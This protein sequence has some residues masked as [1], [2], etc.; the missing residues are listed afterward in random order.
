MHPTVKDVWHD[1]V[2]VVETTEDKGFR[3][4][5]AFDAREYTLCDVSFVIVGLIAF[6]QIH[7]LFSIELLMLRRPGRGRPTSPSARPCRRGPWRSR[8]APGPSAAGRRGPGRG[9]RTTPRRRTRP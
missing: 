9:E 1:L 6:R 2:A 8:P 5:S 3:R 7:D 4:Q